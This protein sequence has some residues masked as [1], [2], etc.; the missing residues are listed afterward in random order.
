MRPSIRSIRVAALFVAVLLLRATGAY[1]HAW[2]ATG[3][4]IA[5]HMARDSL[6]RRPEPRFSSSC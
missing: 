1:V 5:G 4:R 2:C 3:H 6:P